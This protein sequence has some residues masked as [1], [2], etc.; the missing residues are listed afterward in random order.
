MNQNKNLRTMLL[1]FLTLLL[2]ISGATMPFAVARLQ[3]LQ[4]KKITDI[5]QFSSVN[6]TL[7]QNSAI[8]H[9]LQL[10]NIADYSWL[11]YRVST[12]LTS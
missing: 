4:T 7:Q 9:V 11:D 5:R 12:R 6:L 3:D 1:P 10:I 2:I 8:S